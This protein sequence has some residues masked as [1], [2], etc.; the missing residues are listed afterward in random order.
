MIQRFK[1]AISTAHIVTPPVNADDD[2]SFGRNLE[3]KPKPRFFDVIR[4]FMKRTFPNRWKRYSDPIN[5]IGSILIP[6][7]PTLHQYLTD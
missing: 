4:D 7:P 1:E 5:P 6:N 2:V 3:G